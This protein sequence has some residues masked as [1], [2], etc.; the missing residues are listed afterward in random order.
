MSQYS[1]I[2]VFDSWGKNF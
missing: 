1:K 2:A